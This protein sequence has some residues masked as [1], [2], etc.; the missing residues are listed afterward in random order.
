MY[1]RQV[2]NSEINIPPPAIIPS[3]ASPLKEV[4]AKLKK[5]IATAIAVNN[6]AFVILLFV[7]SKKSFNSLL[8][9][10]YVLKR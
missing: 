2:N 4:K 8:E 9:N 10:S 1:K 6:K 5:P 3:C 7:N